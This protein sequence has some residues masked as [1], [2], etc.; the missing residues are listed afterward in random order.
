[1]QG[2]ENSEGQCKSSLLNS[3]Q[4][5]KAVRKQGKLLGA[6]TNLW[7]IMNL[8]EPMFSLGKGSR[9]NVSHTLLLQCLHITIIHLPPSKLALSEWV[10]TAP[11]LPKI[12]TYSFTPERNSPAFPCANHKTLKG[13]HQLK[14]TW[15]IQPEYRKGSCQKC[16]VAG[17][18]SV[19]S[20][21]YSHIL[22]FL[23][24]FL[25]KMRQYLKGLNQIIILVGI[26]QAW[27]TFRQQKRHHDGD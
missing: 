19:F 26:L 2:W 9:S 17:L 20:L 4:E 18:N 14:R 25:L 15:E 22:P 8:V 11:G 13:A 1:M 6:S 24:T 27:M 21:H 16:L 3:K 7:D 23:S 10:N 12:I 5:L